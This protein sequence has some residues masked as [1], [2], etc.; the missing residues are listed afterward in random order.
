M[1]F[2]KYL[3][4]FCAL[5]MS[6]WLTNLPSVAAAQ[7]KM[8]STTSVVDDLSRAQTEQKVRDFLTRE[9]VRK[10]LIARGVSPDE[11][12]SRLASLSQSELNQLSGQI[13]KAQAGGEILVAIVLILLIIF[14][15][16]RI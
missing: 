7:V 4:L 10:Q 16:Q 15:V 11:V 2:P 6:L 8:I 3:K 5:F 9:D 1:K 12:S 13:N 14:L